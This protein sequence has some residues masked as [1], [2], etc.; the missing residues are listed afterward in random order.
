MPYPILTLPYP[1]AKHLHQLLSPFELQDLQIAAGH[2]VINT[3]KPVVTSCK[4]YIVH[5]QGNPNDITTCELLRRTKSF[6]YAT[7]NIREGEP[8]LTKCERVRLYDMSNPALESIN[9]NNILAKTDRIDI[10]SSHISNVFL[11]NVSKFLVQPRKVQING[12]GFDE[13]VTFL[14]ILNIF[15][16]A[17]D[18][19]LNN[20]YFGWLNDLS[21]LGREL[22]FIMIVF[23][24]FE[25]VFS[26]RPEELYNFIENQGPEFRIHLDI[27]TG[28]SYL[29][30]KIKPFIDPR[31]QHGDFGNAN[32][33]IMVGYNHSSSSHCMDRTLEGTD[34]LLILM[35]VFEI[36]CQ[37]FTDSIKLNV[38][39]DLLKLVDSET[40][41][42]TPKFLIKGSDGMFWWI[43]L[44]LMPANEDGCPK[45]YEHVFKT[46]AQTPFCTLLNIDEHVMD[47]EDDK[48]RLTFDAMFQTAKPVISEPDILRKSIP[49]LQRVQESFHDTDAEL[50]VGSER[51]KV[52]RDYLSLISPVFGALFT[53]ETASSPSD[54]VEISNASPNVVKMI[55][56]FCYGK[57]F[58]VVTAAELEPMYKF[59][60]EY[61]IQAVMDEIDQR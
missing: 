3:L 13:D 50:V 12:H 43:T 6:S 27:K 4:D 8:Y 18:I 9:H 38:D 40:K 36:K 54:I 11:H 16:H 46:D 33:H 57:K 61:Q 24:S 15:P 52:H 51:I 32:L 14:T 55:I 35:H 34:E 20:A 1:F 23:E 10:E 49:V 21:S 58:D 28:D 39:N 19:M 45:Q 7:I 44:V 17:N 26:F 2:N 48:V 42:S 37:R 5:F 41:T 56:E 59:A 25:K 31:F 47:R 30:D 29:T 22:Q 53:N 60:K